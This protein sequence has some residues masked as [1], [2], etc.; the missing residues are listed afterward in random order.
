MSTV[1]ANKSK[2]PYCLAICMSCVQFPLWKMWNPSESDH[3]YTEISSIMN[4]P[5]GPISCFL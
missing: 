2:V 3:L 4:M 5:W 1:K